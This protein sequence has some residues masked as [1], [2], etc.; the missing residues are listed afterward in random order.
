MC[1]CV[2]ERERER[3]GGGGGRDLIVIFNVMLLMRFHNNI[4]ILLL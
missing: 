4:I 1:V 3:G 2:C